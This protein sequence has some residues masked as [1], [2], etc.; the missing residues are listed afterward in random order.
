MHR[1]IGSSR[2]IASAVVTAAVIHGA[3]IALGVGGPE[4]MK[5]VSAVALVMAVLFATG[6]LN[7]LRE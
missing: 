3:A 7:W 5:G 1:F 2:L 4:V 6:A